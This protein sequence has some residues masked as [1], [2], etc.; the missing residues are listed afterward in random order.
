[1]TSHSPKKNTVAPSP[2]RP[3]PHEV[4]YRRE[5]KDTTKQEEKK[6]NG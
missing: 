1:M 6:E 4:T 3:R 2:E 5:E